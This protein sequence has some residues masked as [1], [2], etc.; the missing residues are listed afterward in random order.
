MNHLD[1]IS[2]STAKTHLRVDHDASDAEIKRM[3]KSALLYIEKYTN[4]Y[5][6]DRDKEYFLDQCGDIRVYDYPINR[7]VTPVDAKVIRKGL[8]NL[9]SARGNTSITLNIGYSIL[10]DIPSDLIDAALAMIDVWY[11]GSEKQVDTTLIPMDVKQV[12]DTYK[13]F[14]I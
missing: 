12:L 1:V 4:V 2:L 3:I 10:D 8:Y 14:L 5:M 6:V 11:F 9:Y 7:V 13:R